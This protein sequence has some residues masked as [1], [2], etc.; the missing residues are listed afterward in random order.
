M[1]PAFSIDVLTRA[2][3]TPSWKFGESFQTIAG[4]NE[5]R[6]RLIVYL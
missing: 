1:G 3:K 6:A 5:N 2:Q 4:V